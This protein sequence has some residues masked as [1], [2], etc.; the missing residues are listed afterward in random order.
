MR[1][2]TSWG[3]GESWA[4][5]GR[6]LISSAPA[7]HR[8]TAQGQW[9]RELVQCSAALR[10][11]SGAVGIRT[12]VMHCHTAE[13]VQLMQ[14]TATLP[15]GSGQWN[16]CN[17]LPHCLGAVGSGTPASHCLTA[18]GQW[19][20]ELLQS[21]ATPPGGGGQWNSCNARAHQL[22]GRGVPPRRRS[23]AKERTS[24]NALP[25]CLGAVGSAIPTVHCLTTW[26]AVGSGTSAMHCLTAWG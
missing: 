19:A 7:M 2:P 14:C 8:H 15:G 24:W 18:W 5:G 21:I 20:V 6:S 3:D 22:G 9:A 26:G 4:G 23:L 13:A 17:A 12:P 25:H 10:G 16:S 1:R 11:G